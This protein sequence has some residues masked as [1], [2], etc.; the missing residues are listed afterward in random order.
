MNYQSM[1]KQL[2]LDSHIKD[3]FKVCEVVDFN[4][5]MNRQLGIAKT[6]H[7]QI[8]LRISDLSHSLTKNKTR[9]VF[10]QRPRQVHRTT[11]R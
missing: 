2:K 6:V 9:Y 5:T 11:M 4:C 3:D 10:S 7:L 1:I 8:A